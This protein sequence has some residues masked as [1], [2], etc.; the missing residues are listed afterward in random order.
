MPVLGKTLQLHPL[1]SV[2]ICMHGFKS[3]LY[4]HVPV[5]ADLIRVLAHACAWENITIA[6]L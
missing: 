4:F 3:E 2:K 6:S 1:D 5:W